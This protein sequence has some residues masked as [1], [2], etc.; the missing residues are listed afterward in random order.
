MISLRW[1]SVLENVLHPAHIELAKST[2][3]ELL[4]IVL[5]TEF[6]VDC[7]KTQGYLHEYALYKVTII[8]GSF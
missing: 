3:Q 1:I 2:L 7:I 6:Y 8:R 4:C 5:Q